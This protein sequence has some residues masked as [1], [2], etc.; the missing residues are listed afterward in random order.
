MIW[1]Y[2]IR[3]SPE[4]RKYLNMAIFRKG[5]I[6]IRAIRSQAKFGYIADMFPNDYQ[7]CNRGYMRMK[8]VSLLVQWKFVPPTSWQKIVNISKK[9]AIKMAAYCG[10]K[11]MFDQKIKKRKGGGG[12]EGE[13][14]FY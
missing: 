12:A 6:I 10:M 4:I 8:G 7:L 1:N 14:L 2:S 3:K 11:E 5:T 9:H 13:L